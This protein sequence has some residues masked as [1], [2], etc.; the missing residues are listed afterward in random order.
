MGAYARNI[1][2]I[3]S[4]SK[5]APSWRTLH[6]DF[7]EMTEFEVCC[8]ACSAKLAVPLPKASLPGYMN[9]LGCGARLWE[10]EQD[11]SYLRMQSLMRALSAWL[12]T[13]NRGFSLGTRIAEP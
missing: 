12:D 7:K 2:P 6:I 10:G 9:C 5:D 4:S 1:E 8:S 13:E 3:R 11:P